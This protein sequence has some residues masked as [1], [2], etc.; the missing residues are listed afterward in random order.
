MYIHTYIHGIIRYI[1]IQASE[2]AAGQKKVKKR[3]EVKQEKKNIHINGTY[4]KTVEPPRFPE[5]L[6]FKLRILLELHQKY[7][8]LPL[9]NRTL[10]PA[11]LKLLSQVG[12]SLHSLLQICAQILYLF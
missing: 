4:A 3:K 11:C 12:I 1:Y 5:L 2:N 7:F 9:L 8:H 10:W 6:F